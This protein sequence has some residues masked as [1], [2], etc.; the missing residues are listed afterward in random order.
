[1]KIDVYIIIIIIIRHKTWSVQGSERRELNMN[2]E[3][4]LESE[5]ICSVGN[6]QTQCVFGLFIETTR[7]RA[8]FAICDG[9]IL[10]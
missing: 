5:D 3:Y 1:M 4:R 6:T 9:F 7:S 10:V 2:G 8:Q